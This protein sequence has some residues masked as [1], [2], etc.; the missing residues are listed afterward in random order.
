[1]RSLC[2]ASSET[3]GVGGRLSFTG[4]VP[5]CLQAVVRA[6]DTTLGPVPK[7]VPSVAWPQQWRQYSMCPR[8]I[9]IDR[10]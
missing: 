9:D 8:R 3:A 2:L 7:H 4:P 10:V 5:N 6:L 1:M